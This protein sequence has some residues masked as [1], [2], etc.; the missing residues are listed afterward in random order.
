VRSVSWFDR[1][2][3]VEPAGDGVWSAQVGDRWSIGD[4][5]NGG[6][7]VAIALRALRRLGSHGD[8]LSVTAHFLRP[9]TAGERAEVTTEVVKQGRTI[10]TARARLAQAGT[11]RLELLAALGDLPAFDDRSGADDVAEPAPAI[12]PPDECI[13]RSG[14]EQGIELPILDR[15]DIL[16]HPDQ[17]RAGQAGIAEV[18]GWIRL[19]DGAAPDTSALVL[20][21]DAFPPSLFGS[22]G[23][24]GWVPTIELTVHVRRRP[25]PGWILGRFAT[26]DLGG[27]RMIEDGALWDATGALVARSRQLGLLLRR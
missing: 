17:A 9:G 26:G 18:S 22:L 2:T 25:A 7:L 8:P 13:V 20:F 4:N 6:Y 15:L 14:T 21:A 3:R 27:G 16:L 24:V 11:T 23:A 10:T 19:A 1:E 12:P 5:P